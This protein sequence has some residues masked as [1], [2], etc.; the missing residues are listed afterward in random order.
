M[1]HRIFTCSELV[2]SLLF[3]SGL[4]IMICIVVLKNV[5]IL[6]TECSLRRS[7]E[8]DKHVSVR[9][10]CQALFGSTEIVCCLRQVLECP[11][12][13]GMLPSRSPWALQS[14]IPEACPHRRASPP[15]PGQGVRRAQGVALLPHVGDTNYTCCPSE[16]FR[17]MIKMTRQEARMVLVVCSS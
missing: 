14:R 15:I 5:I 16:A 3:F 7:L 2:V 8:S 13:P 10:T 4:K 12:E 17:L 6:F 11:G 9:K 1:L